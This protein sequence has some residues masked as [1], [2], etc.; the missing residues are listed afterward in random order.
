MKT[1]QY[2]LRPFLGMSDHTEAHEDKQL[3]AK[4]LQKR[5]IPQDSDEKVSY[6]LFGIPM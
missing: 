6:T 5:E 3:P 4:K 1:I 2:I